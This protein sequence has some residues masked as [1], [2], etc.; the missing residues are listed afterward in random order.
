MKIMV[1]T[2]NSKKVYWQSSASLGVASS[3]DNIKSFQDLIKI[4][5]IKMYEAKNNGKNCVR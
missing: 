3:E 2:R 1:G 5:D 4:A